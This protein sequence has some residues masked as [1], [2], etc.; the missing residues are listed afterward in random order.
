MPA[1]SFDHQGISSNLHVPLTLF[2]REHRLGFV[3][4]AP[5]DVILS[6][7]DVV[8]PDLLFISNERAQIVTKTNVQGAPDLVI[9]ILSQSTYKKDET[10]KRDLYERSGVREY[11]IVDAQRQAVKVFRRS[12]VRFLAPQKLSAAVGDVLTTPLLPGWA[13]PVEEIFE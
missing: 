11:W 8:Q 9:E 10:L 5:L 2:V 7:H 12:G 4:Y 3:R 6:P 1:P 13:L